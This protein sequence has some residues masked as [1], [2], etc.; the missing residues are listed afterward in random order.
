LAEFLQ[1]Y[2]AKI[3]SIFLQ[4]LAS[5]VTFSQEF[6]SILNILDKNSR[7]ILFINI[8]YTDGICQQIAL[9]SKSAVGVVEFGLLIRRVAKIML[10]YLIYIF[11]LA[12]T[13]VKNHQILVRIRG[14]T[15]GVSGRR[16]G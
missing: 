5:F 2:V 16:R 11:R 4:N 12:F 9:I 7:N 1:K 13:S 10:V 14:A 15:L 8:E 6:S 3:P